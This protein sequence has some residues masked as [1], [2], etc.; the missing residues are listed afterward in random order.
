MWS[1][2]CARKPRNLAI[3]QTLLPL[4]FAPAAPAWLACSCPTLP[5]RYSRRSFRALSQNSPKAASHSY[6]PMRAIRP[7]QSEL[8]SELIARRVD[9][10]VLAS[11]FR[12]DKA[13]D[14]CVSQGIPAVQV[15]RSGLTPHVSSVVPDDM[16]GM[17]LAVDHLVGLGHTRIA[18][19]RTSNSFNWLSAARGICCSDGGARPSRG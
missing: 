14:L 12:G 1:G 19:S 13:L 16:T 11:V 6:W 18:H 10:L 17:R 2:G 8:V 5:I 9:G 7:Q 15:N 4:R 3:D